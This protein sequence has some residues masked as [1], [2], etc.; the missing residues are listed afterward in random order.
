MLIDFLSFIK[1]SSQQLSFKNQK[2]LSTFQSDWFTLFLEVTPSTLVQK[3]TSPE[4]EIFDIPLHFEG[5]EATIS[6]NIDQLINE[7]QKET[8]QPIR[9]IPNNSSSTLILIKLNY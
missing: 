8:L 2:L 3:S 1:V 7:L 4:E 5:T 6:F 9:S